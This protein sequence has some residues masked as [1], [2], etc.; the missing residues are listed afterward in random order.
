MKA[1]LRVALQ[2]A[3]AARSNFRYHDGDS[4]WRELPSQAFGS[5]ARSLVLWPMANDC[6]SVRRLFEALDAGV[7]PVILPKATPALK[8]AALRAEYRG[9][10]FF[11]GDTIEAPAAPALADERVYLV[12]LTSGSTGAPKLVAVNE[13]NLSAGIAAIQEAQRLERVANTG[14]MLPLAYSYALVNQLLGR[15]CMGARFTRCRGCWIR[16]AVWKECARCESKCCAWWHIRSRPWVRWA[17]MR[18]MRSNPCGS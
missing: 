1:S 17:S 13:A 5:H 4:D 12:L 2:D 14:V 9:F 16:L 6:R 11:N 7:V 3:L 15:P 10:G 18:S 8:L